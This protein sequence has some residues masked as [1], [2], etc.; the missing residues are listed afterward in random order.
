MEKRLKEIYNKFLK[1][2]IDAVLEDKELLFQADIPYGV[3]ATYL[4]SIGFE[5]DE[6][7]DTNGW[8]ADFWNTFS[9]DDITLSVSGCMYDGTIKISQK[10]DE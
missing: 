2:G 5:D 3:A 4:E 1:E 8:Q 9:K 10:E 7:F 6:N